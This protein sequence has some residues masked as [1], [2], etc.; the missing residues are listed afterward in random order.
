MA[1]RQGRED[2]CEELVAE[3]V[4]ERADLVDRQHVAVELVEV[5]GELFVSAQRMEAGSCSC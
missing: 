2:I 5:I 1:P 3:G 4:H